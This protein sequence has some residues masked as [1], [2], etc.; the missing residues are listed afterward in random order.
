MKQALLHSVL[1]AIC[2]LSLSCG[3]MPRPFQQTPGDVVKAF[4]LAANEGKYSE[5]EQ[6]LSEDAG[7]AIRGDLGQLAGGFKK[8][9]DQDTKNG[10]ILRV[11]ISKEEIRGEGASVVANIFFKDGS[12][13][14]NDKSSLIKEKGSWKLTGE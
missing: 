8:I 10:T 6:M 13:K 11:E 7:R 5:A 9:C 3:S 1:V 14:D 4:Y 12:T 2:F